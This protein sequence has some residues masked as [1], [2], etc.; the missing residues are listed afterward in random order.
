MF[1]GGMEMEHWLII[2]WN[3]FMNGYLIFICRYLQAEL[4]S[5]GLQYAVNGTWTH[6][7]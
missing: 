2:I 5:I 6:N 4:Y 1:S 3:I 7:F